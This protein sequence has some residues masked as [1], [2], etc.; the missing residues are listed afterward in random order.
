MK[1]QIWK[2]VTAFLLM[3]V[4]IMQSGMTAL[5]TEDIP[6]KEKAEEYVSAQEQE[7]KE[8]EEKT[9]PEETTAPKETA[10]AEE[11]TEP[12]ETMKPEETM[13]PEETMVPGETPEPEETAEPGETMEPQETPENPGEM[14][15]EESPILETPDTTETPIPLETPE[16]TP[17]PGIK[18]ELP[19]ISWIESRLWE[20]APV[21][22]I[23][24]ISP[25]IEIEGN[26]IVFTGEIEYT[27]GYYLAFQ[28]NP[29]RECFTQEGFIKIEYEEEGLGTVRYDAP[30]DVWEK[31]FWEVIIPLPENSLNLV[32]T[33][34]NDGEDE[35]LMSNDE[36][37]HMEDR[38]TVYERYAPGVYE[39]DLSGLQKKIPEID[40]YETDMMLEKAVI[41]S[42]TAPVIKSVTTRDTTAV[43]K[44]VP[45][46][47]V[48]S[49][50]GAEGEN[51][52][53]YYTITLTDKVTGKELNAVNVT[54][55]E[56]EA[57]YTYKFSIIPGE[58]TE[59]APLYTCEIAGLS[60]NK[61]YTVV[62]T[63]HYGAGENELKQSSKAMSFTTKKEMLT[64]AGG[65]LEVS[66]I[67]M[68][69]L[70]ENP[71]D[72]GTKISYD[73]MNPLECN[74]TYA[75]MAEVSNLARALE[76][77]KL[78]WTILTDE[79]KAVDK[80]AVTLKAGVST[81]EAQLEIKKPG[82]YNITAASTVTKEKLS[83]FVVEVK[84]EE[85]KDT[86][87][88]SLQSEIFYF[89][90][91][92]EKMNLDFDKVEKGAL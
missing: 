4:I 19:E 92:D 82:I 22:K 37:I 43:V 40:A 56:Q 74:T 79:N 2:R 70:Q 90:Q 6:G 39:I 42:M 41:T 44:F 87:G 11:S 12:E 57:E 25:D 38:E 62:V 54:E 76:T 13:E 59:K 5:A 1:K 68:E 85:G 83:V 89:Y 8:S 61:A 84:E 18:P 72:A 78:T 24:G 75:L 66:Y 9:E 16:V 31:G 21:E 80:K 58:G 60:S 10:G 7:T 86:A 34:D 47:V 46:D 32:I 49:I 55:E 3:A 77:E 67:K 69:E 26:R 15:P 33:V 50:T 48:R 53:G 36:D 64:A 20:E 45:N 81:F 17:T 30:E 73:E 35:E 63:A 51:E 71:N 65:S 28:I 91:K 52:S 27:D 88:I 14:L 29:D 23:E